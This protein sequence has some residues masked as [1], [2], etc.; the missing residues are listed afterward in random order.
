MNVVCIVG[1]PHGLKGNTFRLTEHLLEGVRRQGGRIEIVLLTP[2]AVLPCLG[3]DTCHR[4][5]KCP[6][7]DAFEAV[8]EAIEGADGLVLAGPNYIGSVSSQLKAFMD[9]CSGT[10][11]CLSFA[12]KYGASVVTSG[13]GDGG[14]VASYMNTFLTMTG[15]RPV[16]AVHAAMAAMP[17]GSFS[18]EVR[19]QA[20]ELG[21]ALVAAWRE[22][23]TDPQ[24]E[25]EMKAFRERMRQLVVWR[26][27]EWPYEYAYWQEQH[28]TA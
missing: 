18:A 25:R 10:I 16:G 22:R 7:E 2:G 21:E 24:V 11:H 19:R 13:A 28:G 20:E 6:Q 12:G 15:V 27:E 9:R 1:S 5:G 14:P 17:E 8:R 23:R 4:T 26:R 3:C